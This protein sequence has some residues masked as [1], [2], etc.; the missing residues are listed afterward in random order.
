MS[1]E[2]IFEEPPAYSGR[3]PGSPLTAWLASLRDHPGRWAKYPLPVH[4]GTTTAITKGQ[5]Y[6][7]AAG[8]FE[9]SATGKG[10]G[11]HKSWLYARYIG[12]ES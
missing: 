6:K 3:G 10:A 8:E 12:G 2:L 1:T 11:K 5:R 7:V 9:V 4:S